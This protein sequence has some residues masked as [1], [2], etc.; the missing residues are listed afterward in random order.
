MADPIIA[1]FKQIEAEFKNSK[2]TDI[3]A[4]YVLFERWASQAA[5]A[6]ELGGELVTQAE[7]GNEAAKDRIEAH[8]QTTSHLFIET[9]GAMNAIRLA[10]ITSRLDKIEGTLEFV[11][12]ALDP[13]QT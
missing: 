13:T 5:D 12:E 4:L 9:F 10:D 1:A 2:A 6:A 11:K 3:Q 7:A 8:G